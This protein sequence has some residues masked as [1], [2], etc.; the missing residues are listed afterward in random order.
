MSVIG[1]LLMFYRW[2]EPAVNACSYCSWRP[3]QRRPTLYFSSAQKQFIFLLN[4]IGTV[5]QMD[6]LTCDVVSALVTAVFHS[7]INVI[8]S[9]KYFYSHS[10]PPVGQSCFW[11]PAVCWLALRSPDPL[12]FCPSP[13]SVTVIVGSREIVLE[14][15]LSVQLRQLI[16]SKRW[17]EAGLQQKNFIQIMWE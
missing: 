15:Q 6:Q 1:I 2:R 3:N 17:Q 12:S 8:P 14:H 5:Q 4:V 11:H 16:R 9:L 10:A 13:P 7:N